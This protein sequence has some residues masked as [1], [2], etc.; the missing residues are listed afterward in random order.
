[1]ALTV[2]DLTHQLTIGGWIAPFGKARQA[3]QSRVEAAWEAGN[4]G[5][6]LGALQPWTQ[7]ILLLQSSGE[8]SL[9]S[10]T[11][12]YLAIPLTVPYISTRTFIQISYYF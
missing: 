8:L 3:P 9:Q 7:V 2:P 5:R 1:M 12:W 11:V 6:V 4:D 10:C